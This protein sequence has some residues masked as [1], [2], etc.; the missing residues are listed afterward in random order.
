MSK[1]SRTNNLKSIIILVILCILSSS[2]TGQSNQTTTNESFEIFT[3]K[4]IFSNGVN[5]KSNNSLIS[6]K[7][8]IYIFWTIFVFILI[9]IIVSLV[10]MLACCI[11]S[12]WNLIRN[13]K[14]Q[15]YLVE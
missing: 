3:N 6:D 11:C 13:N 4:P 14:K 7:N 2:A 15:T 5:V 1:I 8:Q 12:C 9:F 10:S